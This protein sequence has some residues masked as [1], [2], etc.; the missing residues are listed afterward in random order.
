LF[1]EK[2]WIDDV[3]LNLPHVLISAAMLRIVYRLA[4]ARD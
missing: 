1:N 4:P 3:L 2:R